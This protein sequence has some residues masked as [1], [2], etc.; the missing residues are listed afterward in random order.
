MIAELRKEQPGIPSV[1]S[2]LTA[3]GHVDL[4]DRSQPGE[5]FSRRVFFLAFFG[6]SEE[7]I[8]ER[9]PYLCQWTTMS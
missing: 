6:K 7:R 5:A 3:E 9:T 2:L 8:D 1:E 4:T